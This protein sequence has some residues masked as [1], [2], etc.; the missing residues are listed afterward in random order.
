MPLVPRKRLGR[1]E[2][3]K[4]RSQ[5]IGLAVLVLVVALEDCFNAR[6]ARVRS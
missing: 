5:D 2:R 4:T 3:G 6:M 1:R